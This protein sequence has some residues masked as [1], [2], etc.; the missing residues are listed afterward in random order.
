M[1]QTLRALGLGLLLSLGGCGC[2]ETPVSRVCVVQA[3]CPAGQFCDEGIC[4]DGQPICLK[5][6]IE[7]NCQRCAEH[8]DCPDGARCSRSGLCLPPQ[9]DTDADCTNLCSEQG[10]TIETCQAEAE[11][12]WRQ[13]VPFVCETDAQC[14]DAFVEIADGLTAACVAARL[15]L[16]QPMRRNLRCWDGLLR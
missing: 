11:S 8:S 6:V 7:E 10:S 3:D 9:C 12:G 2:D 13:C 16:P 4:R 15:P 14:S 1:I 5:G